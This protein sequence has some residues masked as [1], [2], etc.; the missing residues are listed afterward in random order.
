MAI[1]E[2]DFSTA[3]SYDTLYQEID[4]LDLLDR[5]HKRVVELEENSPM[6]YP[7]LVIQHEEYKALIYYTGCADK[8][9]TL[10]KVPLL[11]A[12]HI[13]SIQPFLSQLKHSPATG[14]VVMGMPTIGSDNV[15][16]LSPWIL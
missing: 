6:R 12:A 2:P 8:G 16:E 3:L 9:R 14:L 4:V 13:E 10:I 11:R 7:V 5:I 1:I 15:G